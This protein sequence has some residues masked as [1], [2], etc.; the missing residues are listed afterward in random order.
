MVNDC[1]VSAACLICQTCNAEW[2]ELVMIKRE[3]KKYKKGQQLIVEGDPFEGIFFIRKGGLKVHKNWQNQ[4]DLIIRWA[5][6][7]DVIGHRGYGIPELYPVSATCLEPVEACFID[8][9]FLQASLLSNARF[10]HA[11]LNVFSNDLKIAEERMKQL[12]LMDVKGRL[13][14][15]LFE[16][17][18][19]FG[20]DDNGFINISISRQDIA[21]YAGTIYETVFK[22]FTE[23]VRARIIK[24]EQKKLGIIRPFE[25]AKFSAE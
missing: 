17:E 2:K 12:A 1:T 18:K 23:L 15:S 10:C 25:L 22:I 6:V 8:K 21:S 7:G 20:K 19:K 5:S 9:D 16:L 14:L 24:T 3:V 13:S 11:L 4:K